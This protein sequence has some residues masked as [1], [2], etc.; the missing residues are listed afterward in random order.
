M[1]AHTQTRIHPHT[2]T[3]DLQ[4]LEKRS[5]ESY[6]F[7]MSKYQERLL[8]HIEANPD[9]IQPSFR[10]NEILAKLREPLRDLSVS[11]TNFDWGLQH[12]LIYVLDVTLSF[13]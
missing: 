1:H 9:F 5:E 13:V 7:R 10:K 8:A 3:H 2:H 6:F 4:P 12:V 11:R